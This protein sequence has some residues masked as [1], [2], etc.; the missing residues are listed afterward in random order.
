LRSV[1]VLITTVV[2][3]AITAISASATPLLAITFMTPCSKSGG[4]VSALAVTISWAP[5]SGS[6]KK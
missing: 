2:P 6:L 5:V 3:C 1:S 4:V